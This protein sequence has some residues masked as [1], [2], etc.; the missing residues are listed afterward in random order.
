MES[1]SKIINSLS[2]KE[3]N[4]LP[5]FVDL[6]LDYPDPVAA[7]CERL[8]TIGGAVIH[9]GTIIEANEFLTKEYGDAVVLST[10]ENLGSPIEITGRSPRDFADIDVVILEAKIGVAE[11][12]AVW[13]TNEAMPSQVL[14]FICQHLIVTLRTKD[15]VTDMHKAY[16]KIGND[17]YSFGCFIAGPSKTADIEQSLVLGAHG[18]KTMTVILLTA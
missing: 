13:L 16:E 11:N 3:F 15:I 7:F 6:C 17:G 14:P 9:A 4:E 10:V 1:R 18:P 8:R 12:G 5:D 2:D